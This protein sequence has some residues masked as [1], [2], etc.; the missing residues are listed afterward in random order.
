MVLDCQYDI[1]VKGQGQVYLIS[2]LPKPTFIFYGVFIFKKFTSL[3]NVDGW[4]PLLAQWI[5]MACILQ[6]R[7]LVWFGL[8][9][10]VTQVN[11]HGHGGT[12][13]SPNHTFS[14]ASLNN[15]NPFA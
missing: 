11:S 9:L 2:V 6:H 3:V 8:L 4:C 14:C 7:F 13:S 15:R 12:V 1:G 5:S 10:Y